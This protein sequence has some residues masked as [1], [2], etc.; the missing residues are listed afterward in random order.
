MLLGSGATGAKVALVA[1]GALLLADDNV[2]IDIEVGA[3]TTLDLVEPSGT[4]AYDMRG[5][6]ARWDVRITLSDRAK[7]VWHGEP[8]VVSEGAHVVRTLTIDLAPDATC[9]LRET[10]VLGRTGE[11]PG[12]LQSRTR[13]RDGAGPLLAEDLEL[14]TRS[15]VGGMLGTNR[16]IDTVTALGGTPVP[17]DPSDRLLLERNGA[18]WRRLAASAHT[19]SLAP[20]WAELRQ[21]VLNPM[22]SPEP[23]IVR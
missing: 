21:W 18:V 14:S 11:C 22:T 3:G 8:F 9:L 23:T 2:S 10:L 7:L 20:V 15:Q 13:V 4:V 1:Q 19:A 12:S 17:A 5:S 16:V 6:G